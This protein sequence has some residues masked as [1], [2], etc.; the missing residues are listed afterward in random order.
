MRSSSSLTEEQRIAV[1]ALFEEGFGSVAV[2]TH[3]GVSLPA[4]KRLELLWRVRGG[5]AL[6]ARPTKQSYPYET[7]LEIVRRFL[8]GESRVALA[9]EYTIPSPNLIGDW[10][11]RFRRAGE[12]GLRPQPKGRPRKDPDVASSPQSELE[13]LRDENL[14]L[15]IKVD[16]LEKLKA[17][18]A[19]ERQ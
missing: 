13:R 14:R 8:A 4:V 11:R 7:K 5:E 18:R 19:Q 9:Q 12:D 1:I 16:Y 15:R 6:V 17:L 2:A 3:L 10:A